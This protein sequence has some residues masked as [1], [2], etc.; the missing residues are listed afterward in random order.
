M[1]LI[2][3]YITEENQEVRLVI[4]YTYDLESA[5]DIVKLNYGAP[6][7]VESITGGEVLYYNKEHKKIA[8]WI[9]EIGLLQKEDKF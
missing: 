2:R 5:V 8:F 7:A 4:G 3:K 9:R 1:Y 6:S